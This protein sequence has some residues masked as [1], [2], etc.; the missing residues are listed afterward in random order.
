MQGKSRM[1]YQGITKS[2]L[3]KL[4]VD[5]LLKKPEQTNQTT[6]TKAENQTIVFVFSICN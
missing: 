3:L 2:A 4:L 6:Q 5:V 1:R